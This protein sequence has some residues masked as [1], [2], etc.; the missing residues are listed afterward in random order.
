M[1]MFLNFNTPKPR[2]FQYRPWFYDE[3]KERLE[4]MKA[5]ARAEL[6]AEKNEAGNAGGLQMG[7]LTENRNNSKLYRRKLE[8]RSALRFLL[9]LIALLGIFYLWQP[10]LFLAFWKF[11]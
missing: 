10:E 3:R 2:Q 9:I 7:F 11:K 1:A 8:Q 4:K 6:E 5:R